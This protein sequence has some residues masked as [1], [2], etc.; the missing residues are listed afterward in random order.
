[1]Q[2]NYCRMP[3]ERHQPPWLVAEFAKMWLEE[4]K[5]DETKKIEEQKRKQKE[6]EQALAEQRKQRQQQPAHG[7]GDTTALTDI[8][9]ASRKIPLPRGL[10]IRFKESL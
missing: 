1:M 9:R 4:E 7:E 2:L 8:L 10:R 5:P 3:S 6:R